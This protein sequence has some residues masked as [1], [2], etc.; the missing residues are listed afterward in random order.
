MNW[1]EG[2]NLSAYQ[3]KRHLFISSDLHRQLSDCPGKGTTNFIHLLQKA[4]LQH[5]D[6]S[7]PAKALGSLPFLLSSFAYI[8]GEIAKMD[9]SKI[10][11]DKSMS[12]FP[13]ED[14]GKYGFWSEWTFFQSMRNH[15]GA[16]YGGMQ[17]IIQSQMDT[18]IK[19]LDELVRPPR[20]LSL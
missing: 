1:P 11:K 6:T 4:A 16:I 20:S 19:E 13:E 9:P 8:V 14:A 17:L 7:S 15:L 3:L 10:V 12:I 5:V 18:V 2:Y